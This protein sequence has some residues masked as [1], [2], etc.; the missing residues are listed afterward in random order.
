M[1]AAQA[2]QPFGN[3]LQVVELTYQDIYDVLNEQYDEDQKYFL[4]MSGLKY[5][6]TTS[7][8]GDP[9]KPFKVVRAFTDKGVAIDPKASYKVVVNDFL[10]GGGDGFATF[11]K[12]KLIGAINPDTEVFIKYIKDKEAKHETIA[13]DFLGIKTF[14]TSTVESSKTSDDMGHHDI[15]KRVYRDRDGHIVDEEIISDLVTPN[16]QSPTK[17]TALASPQALAKTSTMAKKQELPHTGSKENQAGL[18][19]MLGLVTLFFAKVSKKKKKTNQ[20]TGK[21]SSLSSFK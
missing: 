5:T 2:V 8:S 11:R 17:Q 19:S 18:L 13:A 6:F 1:G 20:K 21:F 9:S 16:P 3:I 7:E 10:F 14:V 12:G 4:Q 15:V